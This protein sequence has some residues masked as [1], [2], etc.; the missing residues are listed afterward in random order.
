MSSAQGAWVAE[1]EA[2]VGL[3][4]AGVEPGVPAA[5]AAE[6]PTAG[7]AEVLAVVVAAEAVRR[8]GG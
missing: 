1:P 4:V 3:A 7:V 2:A 8:C 5:G 6:E